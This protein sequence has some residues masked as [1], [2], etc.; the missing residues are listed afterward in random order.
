MVPDA[1]KQVDVFPW[2]GFLVGSRFPQAMLA[3]CCDGPGFAI[4]RVHAAIGEKDEN[5]RKFKGQM[6]MNCK[7]HLQRSN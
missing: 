7:G 5:G 6:S 2:S 1:I 4:H 3:P